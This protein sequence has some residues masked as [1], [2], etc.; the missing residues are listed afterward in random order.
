MHALFVLT[1]ALFF[2]VIYAL[3]LPRL[4]G[5]QWQFVAS[6]PVRRRANGEWQSLNLTWYGVFL[7]LGGTIAVALFLLTTGSIGVPITIAALCVA[8]I[9]GA[10]LPAARL[11]VRL[12]EKS[13]HG[14]TV[15]GAS[16]VGILLAPP[17]VLALQFCGVKC[18][19]SAL[20]ALPLLAALAIAYV[21][22]EGIGRLACLSFGCCRGCAID[23]LHPRLRQ[24]L[25]PLATSWEGD[26]RNALWGPRALQNVVPV[27][28][29]TCVLYTMLAL[30]GLY[31]FLEGS[32]RLAFAGALVPALLWRVLSEFLRADW[33]GGRKFSV[34][35]WMALFAGLWVIGWAATLP[36]ATAMPQLADGLTLLWQTPVLLLLQTV[37]ATMFVYTGISTMTRGAIRFSAR[38]RRTPTAQ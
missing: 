17:L 37:F 19:A 35:Q 26:M 12:V 14:F 27:Q 23:A 22:G 1:L 16:F 28:A 36:A 21:L 32:Y 25:A 10:C 38:R 13:R 7:A 33:R 34:Y 5:A 9:L 30:G 18:N 24:T 20:P 2:A 8:V 3:L 6:V 31:A 11:I 4:T 15:G 29:I